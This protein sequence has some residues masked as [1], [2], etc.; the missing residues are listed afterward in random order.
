MRPRRRRSPEAASSRENAAS[1]KNAE[2]PTGKM[3]RNPIR[4]VPTAKVFGGE[5]GAFAPTVAQENLRRLAAA[6]A[7][8]VLVPEAP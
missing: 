4:Q 6:F 5:A 2:K 8:S 1:L 7:L 3:L